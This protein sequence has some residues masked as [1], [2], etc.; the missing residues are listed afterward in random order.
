MDKV[1]GLGT[2]GCGI[3]HEFSAYPEYRIYKIGSP[4][5]GDRANLDIPLCADIQSYE[6]AADPVEI[7]SYLRSVRRDDEVLL[8]VGG[9]EPISGLSLVVLEQLKH[10]K[11]T[12]VYVL[13][14]LEVANDTQLRD[15]KIVFNVLQQ[16]ARSGLLECLFLVDRRRV[17]EMV[18]DV[19]IRQY[20]KS[21]YNLVAY[22]VAMINYYDHTEAIVTNKI[23][24]GKLS[25]IGTFGISSLEETAE[26]KYL[27]DLQKEKDV[28]YYYGIPQ[29][30]LDSDNT[31]MRDIK[32]QTK[33]FIGES[34]NGS[35]S[36]Y[37]TTF[38]NRMVLFAAYSQEIQP[39]S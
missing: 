28:H 3:A 18:G 21:V 39:L 8:V 37:S 24:P 4:A 32:S 34:V 29:S 19:S 33:Q 16:Y 6:E 30:E 26:K 9:G 25:R 20:E 1:I 27:F 23:T 2:T 22:V 11:P 14:D 15:N 5:P 10:T 17:E 35:F 38:E 13:P 7:A 31:L 36:V 12:V